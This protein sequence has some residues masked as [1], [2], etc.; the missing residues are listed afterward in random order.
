MLVFAISNLVLNF[1]LWT[2]PSYPKKKKKIFQN[3]FPF[4][5]KLSLKKLVSDSLV[6]CDTMLKK[7][8]WLFLSQMSPKCPGTKSL[9][10]QEGS[11][12]C[13]FLLSDLKN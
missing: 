5:V 7:Y 11:M 9:R 3:D 10:K 8:S 2:K 1:L 6:V 4:C 12:L 13:L